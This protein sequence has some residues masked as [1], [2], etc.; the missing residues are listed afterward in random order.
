VEINAA[1][2]TD[3]NSAMNTSPTFFYRR[4]YGEFGRR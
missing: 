1:P 4:N 3:W 2:S